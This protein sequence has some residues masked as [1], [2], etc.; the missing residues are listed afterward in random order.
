MGVVRQKGCSNREPPCLSG[1]PTNRRDRHGHCVL[2][3]QYA[4]GGVGL[5]ARSQARHQVQRKVQGDWHDAALT[6]TPYGVRVPASCHLPWDAGQLA[7]GAPHTVR[8]PYACQPRAYRTYPVPPWH[9]GTPRTT[10][11]PQA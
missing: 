1:R 7:P 4:G 3:G 10:V 2:P 9:P 11:A 5:S 6:C 8:K